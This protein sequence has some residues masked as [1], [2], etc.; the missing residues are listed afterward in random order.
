MPVTKPGDIIKLGNHVLL[1]GDATK[2]EDVAKLM[3]GSKTS[4]ISCDPPYNIGLDYSKGISTRGKVQ[5]V[6]HGGKDKK[7]SPAYKAFMDASVKNALSVSTKDAHVFFWCDENFV[8]K[9]Q[10]IF[11]A[12]GIHEP[13]DVSHGSKTIST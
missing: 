8:G 11:E 13:E 6:I 10:E 7:S 5:R 3:G 9:M 2:A 12:N 4:F 1:C